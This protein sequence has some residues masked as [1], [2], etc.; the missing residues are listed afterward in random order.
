VRTHSEIGIGG[1]GANQ[2]PCLFPSST[3][4]I[5]ALLS[6]AG[7]DATVARSHACCPHAEGNAKGHKGRAPLVDHLDHCAGGGGRLCVHCG[8]RVVVHVPQK[9]GRGVRGATPCNH[10]RAASRRRTG[11]TVLMVS[12]AGAG[13]QRLMGGLA[14]ATLCHETRLRLPYW[15][16]T[17]SPLRRNYTTTSTA[18]LRVLLSASHAAAYLGLMDVGG[19][20]REFNDTYDSDIMRPSFTETG[21]APTQPHDRCLCRYPNADMR[22]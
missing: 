4:L 1:H 2:H 9:P 7:W 15:S 13:F 10:T 12:M 3:L 18:L 21:E 22:A 14:S 11:R 19:V 8:E 17:H 16:H 6:R 5:V 20:Q